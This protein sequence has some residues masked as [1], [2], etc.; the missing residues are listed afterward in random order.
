MTD[1]PQ[2]PSEVFR[3]RLREI[4]KDLGLSR[5]KLSDKLRDIGHPIDA[6]TLA[7]IESGRKQTTSLDDVLAIALA[8]EVPPLALIL[9]T[10]DTEAALGERV[11][12]GENVQPVGMLMLLSWLRAEEPLLGE[13]R[14]VFY[15]A[16]RRTLT[17]PELEELKQKALGHR[18]GQP[19]DTPG[20]LEYRLDLIAANEAG[21]IEDSAALK[22][23][24]AEIRD[25][26]DE[27][28]V[29][30]SGGLEVLLEIGRA[31]LLQE[32]LRGHLFNPP[33]RDPQKEEQ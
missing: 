25:M 26:S 8:L 30:L 12:I 10:P 16:Q 28:V 11:A 32:Y 15:Q 13:D 4:R 6:L 33:S 5:Q 9:P 18:H 31:R 14:R 20:V 17:C 19:I 27:E 7:R 24:V 1:I 22:R 29:E 3:R 2:S 23:G 21:P